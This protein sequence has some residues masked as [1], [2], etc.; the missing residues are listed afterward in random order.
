VFW[1]LVVGWAFV[2]ALLLTFQVGGTEFS[3][4]FSVW[5]YAVV[6]AASGLV[7]A[8]GAIG[9]RRP[10]WVAW[11]LI[12]L[13]VLGWGI[14]EIIWVFYSGLL[15][16]EVPYPGLADVFYVGAYPLV[17]AGVLMLPHVHARKWERARLSLDALA[18][19]VAISAIMWTFY[20]KDAIYLDSEAGLLENFINLA[21]PVGDLILLVGLLVLATRR[22]QYQFD[23]RLLML[24]LATLITTIA[25]LAY[26]FQIEAGTYVDGGRLDALWLVDYGLYAVAAV[27]VAGPAKLR[28][29][30][31]QPARLWP[32]IAP[33]T[34]VAVLFA[35]T[36][37]ELGGQ[38]TTLQVATAVVG[39]LI[40]VRQAVAIRETRE[41]VEKQRNDLVASISHELRTPLTAMAGFTEILDTEPDLDR[42]D[43]IEMVSIVNAQT[44]HLTR[45]VGDLVE[46]ARDKLE[47]TTL[48]YSTID[49]TALIDSAIGMLTNG[50]ST[51]RITTSVQPGLTITGDIDRLRQVLVNYLTNASRYGNGAVEVHAHAK[52]RGQTTIEVHDNGRG[53]PKKYE[54]TIWDRFQRGEY[55]YLSKVQGSGLGLAIARQLVAAHGGN[56]GHRSSERLGGA[57]FWLTVPTS[58]T[59]VPDSQSAATL[60]AL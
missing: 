12:G 15:E 36:M 59:I 9:G 57:C 50:A 8:W 45:I 58:R 24:A 29:Q 60:P 6:P 46:V 34:A 13:G 22:S 5:T 51:A 38:A 7:L 10:G 43:R 19:T 32:M 53:I 47:S 33:Y 28:E 49:V 18:G 55:T 1:L 54:V 44:K 42:T 3:F 16:V 52:A 56:T 39:L 41:V 4:S 30:A 48:T 25:D 40:I 21:Y 14:G 20:L 23:G 31:D 37:G 35:V 11:A 2:G 26:V 27:L 17:F